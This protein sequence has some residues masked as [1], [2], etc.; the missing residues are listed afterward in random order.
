MLEVNYPTIEGIRPQDIIL[1]L[2]EYVKYIF[3]FSL[4]I[5]GL[6]VFA[7]LIYGGFRYLTSAGSPA[8]QKDA[9]S[10]IFAGFLGLIVLLSSYLI[11]TTINPQLVFLSI[12]ERVVFPSGPPI[13]TRIEER[14]TLL[15]TEIPIGGLIG[16]LLS[17]ERVA[18][19][20]NVT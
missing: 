18:R 20:K 17:S 7:V 10:Q 3:N 5:A 15:Y 13:E 6:V 2:P 16:D 9:R 4:A 14:E 8:V 11:L 12:P 1:T 19:I